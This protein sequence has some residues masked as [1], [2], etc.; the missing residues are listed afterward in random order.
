MLAGRRPFPG[1]SAAAVIGAILHTEPAPVDVPRPVSRIYL[2][3]LAKDAEDR[4]QSARDL[5]RE[6]Q[7]V[8]LPKAEEMTPARVSTRK[9]K[10]AAAACVALVLAGA[11]LWLGMSKREQAYHVMIRTPQL[12]VSDG[13]RI[14]VSP[15]GRRIAMI[16]VGDAGAKHLMIRALD[17]DIALAVAGA[18][19]VQN[20]PFWSPDG[21]S[22]GYFSKDSLNKVDV[23]TGKV[24][25]LADTG[26]ITRGGCW[27]NGQ[28]LFTPGTKGAI[29]RIAESGGE[30]EQVTF[31]ERGQHAYPQF[32]PDGKRFL[33]TATTSRNQQLSVGTLGRRETRSLGAITGN[34][35]V[36][37]AGLFVF[38]RV[39]TLVAQRV[40]PGTLAFL[41]PPSSL[42]ED[43]RYVPI[44]GFGA[45][46]VSN[47]GVLAFLRGGGSKTLLTWFD[48]QGKPLSQIGAPGAYWSLGLSPDESKIA[49]SRY[50]HEQNSDI[51][52]GDMSR[53]P[54]SRL[55]LDTHMSTHPV[56]S[57]DAQHL[58]FASF[59]D[60]H[61]VLLTR[62][63]SGVQQVQVLGEVA[64]RI[65]PLDWSRDG[66]FLAF[67]ALPERRAS[68]RGEIRALRMDDTKSPIP[69]LS[70]PKSSSIMPQFS[71]DGRWLAY[72]S[73]ETGIF[74]VYVRPFPALNREKWPVSS[75]GGVQ[76]RW[77]AD[78]REIFYLDLK[79]HVVS[80]PVAPQAGGLQFG[81]GKQLFVANVPYSSLTRFEY[82]VSRDGQRIL[83]NVLAEEDNQRVDLFIHWDAVLR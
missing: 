69:L 57:P 62:D 48:R 56:W 78:G 39:E 71:P 32:L 80:V 30:P 44:N 2:T 14:A 29:Y 72:A 10:T 50:D 31:P 23:T 46:A 13:P 68:G 61:S 4:W 42:I 82:V 1:D 8:A 81:R 21:N 79:N 9:W 73:N 54:G 34:V 70:D 27:A 63:A 38:R 66:R 47:N 16:T 43:V 49:V 17:S 25:R 41:G 60:G 52:V 28:I 64:E 51:W 75:G 7:W 36:A 76:P 19:D 65:G 67:T 45:F 15:D 37:S 55:I 20:Y 59:R 58:S 3:C 33:F 5:Q 22:I 26:P 40:D 53:G 11:L 12:D 77:R 83:A 35:A 6:L 18:D 24:T 74:E